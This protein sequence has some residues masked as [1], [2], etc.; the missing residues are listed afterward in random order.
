MLLLSLPFSD[1]HGAFGLFRG[2]GSKEM[3][4]PAMMKSLRALLDATI[5]H[6]VAQHYD[7]AGQWQREYRA[8]GDLSCG[9]SY[10]DFYEYWVDQMDGVGGKLKQR[11]TTEEVF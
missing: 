4:A 8:S 9:G 7:E 1:T 5:V 3:D 6:G 11:Y 2:L 10:D